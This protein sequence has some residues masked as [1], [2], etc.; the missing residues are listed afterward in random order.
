[1][2]AKIFTLLSRKQ[3]TKFALLVLVQFFSSFLDAIGIISIL[4]FLMLI[5]DPAQ[6]NGD[7]FLS[8]I[9][10]L[11]NNKI[12]IDN[13]SFNFSGRPICWLNFNFH[14]FKGLHS[15]NMNKYIEENRIGL[16]KDY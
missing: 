3:R 5:I 1:M 14:N 7:G 6:L 2:I 10:S 15:H 12:E 16:S 8:Y 4:P 13:D 11:L 9:Y